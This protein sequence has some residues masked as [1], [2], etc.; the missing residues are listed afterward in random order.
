VKCQTKWQ[1]KKNSYSLSLKNDQ[2]DPKIVWINSTSHLKEYMT[3]HVWYVWQRYEWNKKMATTLM[4]ILAHCD[5]P[6][7]RILHPFCI[8]KTVQTHVIMMLD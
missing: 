4:D 5:I 1:W 7:P 2:V 3:Q 6:Y 8:I